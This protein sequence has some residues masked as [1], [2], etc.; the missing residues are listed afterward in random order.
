LFLL[1]LVTIANLLTQPNP[2]SPTEGEIASL[3]M[4]DPKSFYKTARE[5]TAKYASQN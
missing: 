1:V 4:K 3:L 5:W 2:Q